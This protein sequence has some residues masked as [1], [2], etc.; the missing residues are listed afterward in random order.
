MTVLAVPS[1]VNPEDSAYVENPVTGE[2]FRFHSRPDEPATDPLEFDVWASPEMS[3]LAEH[4]HPKQDETFTVSSGTVEVIREGVK[5]RY[6][7]GEAV[8]IEA[9]T[10]HTWTNAGDTRLH[11]RVRI[12][13]GLQTEAFL[14]DLATLAQRGEVKTDGAP[15][16]LRVAALY[17][18]YGYDLLHLASP[19]LRVQKV[20]FGALAPV[21][22]G[23]GYRA[24]PVED[25]DTVRR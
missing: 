10:P 9:A 7:E 13:P 11:L 24:N 3:P 4:V 6:R 23:L 14:R 2:Q 1:G 19:P 20:L 18:A 12:Q 5:S 21:A 22:S 17:D 8:T 16:L 25:A 15:P